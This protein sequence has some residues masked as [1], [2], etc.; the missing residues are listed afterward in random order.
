MPVHLELG[1]EEAIFG[2]GGGLITPLPL[3]EPPHLDRTQRAQPG[4]SRRCT[5]G[6]SRMRNEAF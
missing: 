6:E 2:T 1:G 4:C 3:R 5:S